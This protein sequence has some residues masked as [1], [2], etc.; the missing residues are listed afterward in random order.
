M[1]L[2]ANKRNKK[3]N[4]FYSKEMLN[5]IDEKSTMNTPLS[6]YLYIYIYM[7]LFFLSFEVD[8]QGSIANPV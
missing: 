5:N 2:K 4:C 6:L 7:F 8:R 1:I 3:K